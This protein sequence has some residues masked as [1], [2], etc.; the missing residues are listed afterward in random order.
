VAPKM[1]GNKSLA[2]A[3][4]ALG[5]ALA[6]CGSSSPSQAANT[7]PV[8]L[9]LEG[10]LSGSHAAI[11]QGMIQGAKLALTDINASGGVLGHHVNLDG[12]DDVNDP[13]DAV[14]AADLLTQSDNVKAII[15]PT[16]VTAATVLPIATRAGIPD[17]MWGGGA[18]FDAVT[19]PNFFRMTPSD[20]QQAEALMVYAF[21]KGWTNVALAIGNGAADQSLLPGIMVAAQK[22]H[23]TISASVTISVGATSFRSEIQNLFANHPQ[24]IIGQFDIPS[25]GVL[26]GELRQQNL[27]GTPWVA[28][29]LW[30]AG[31]FV[32]SVGAQVA[33]GPIYIENSSAGAGVGTDAFFA[34]LKKQTGNTTPQAGNES[35]WDATLTWALGAD[36]AGTFNS[37][38]VEQG[39]VKIA[40]GPGTKCGDYATCYGL[41]KAGKPINFEGA[42]STVDFDKYHN[43]SG[44]FD[45]LQY[46]PDGTTTTVTTLTPSDLVSAL[47]N[48]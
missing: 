26:F 24:A 44:A 28:G 34:A 32:T 47:G 27:L 39:I 3:L 40:D 2:P 30:Y 7:G 4:A 20:S 31:Q 6:A 43:V 5:L 15:G 12:Q 9:G 1:V 16:S 21:K 46:K 14:S 38:Q 17:L 22:L 11:G 10:P 33:S 29:A 23:M 48:G 37:P 41:I 19:N 45:I 25:A 8:N 35:M 13:A 18:A 42:A 36:E